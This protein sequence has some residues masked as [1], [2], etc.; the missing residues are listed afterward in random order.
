[1]IVWAIVVG[2]LF[3]VVMIPARLFGALC[4]WIARAAVRDRKPPIPPPR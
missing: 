4:G 3:I 1:M 2:V